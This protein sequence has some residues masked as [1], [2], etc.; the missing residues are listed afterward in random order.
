MGNNNEDTDETKSRKRKVE[1]GSLLPLKKRH[2]CKT[3]EIESFVSQVDLFSHR[4]LEFY[5]T[6][7]EEAKLSHICKMFQSSSL[8][9][10]AG[11][12]LN[13][14][15]STSYFNTF[16]SN[17]MFPLSKNQLEKVSNDCYFKEAA[18]LLVKDVKVK[19]MFIMLWNSR[20]EDETTSIILIQVVRKEICNLCYGVQEN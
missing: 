12:G 18:I 19:S 5:F 11:T 20:K 8:Q 13:I 6:T 14:V 3:V 15:A 16:Q 2:Q 7:E 17:G 10:K 9:D 1:S 4:I